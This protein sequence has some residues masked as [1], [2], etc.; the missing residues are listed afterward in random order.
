MKAIELVDDGCAEQTVFYHGLRVGGWVPASGL[1]R[2]H[3]QPKA[4]VHL[5]DKR[6]LV[7]YL[8]SRFGALEQFRK[9]A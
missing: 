9:Q 4:S 3:G 7:I 8:V 2:E 5:A 1:F 6:A